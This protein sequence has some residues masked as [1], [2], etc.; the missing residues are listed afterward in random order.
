MPAEWQCFG[1]INLSRT[2]LRGDNTSSTS[3]ATHSR[4]SC[5]P[6]TKSCSVT[7]AIS[8]EGISVDCRSSYTIR[9]STSQH[10]YFAVRQCC[11][12]STRFEASRLESPEVWHFHLN[13]IHL[14]STQGGCSRC[15]TH[16]QAG[17][18]TPKRCILA[19][20][21]SCACR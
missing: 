9:H 6:G 2:V 18:G 1:C 19:N 15:C 5:S 7:E 20:I 4:S 14:P 17:C 21:R 3:H 16:I 11:R 13:R 10:H 12:P 8:W